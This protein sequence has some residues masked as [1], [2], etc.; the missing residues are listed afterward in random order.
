LT[1]APSKF[2]DIGDEGAVLFFYRWLAH[3]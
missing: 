2:L 3:S 1:G